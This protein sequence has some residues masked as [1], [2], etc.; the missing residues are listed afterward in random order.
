[1][2]KTT[3]KNRY[4]D[5]FEFKETPDGIK[6]TGAFHYVR[7]GYPNDYSKAYEAYSND[8]DT[9]ERLTLG[10]FM[11]KVHEYDDKY[12]PGPITKKYV[13]LVFSKVGEFNMVDPSGGP[14]ICAGTDMSRFGLSGAVVSIESIDNGYLL[15]I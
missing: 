3:Y 5:I 2:K 12:Q 10:E 8:V 15:K 4:G 7:I 6:W 11:N 13:H 9:D 14:C 1:M